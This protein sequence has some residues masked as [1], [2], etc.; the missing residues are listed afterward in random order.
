MPHL[1]KAI[2]HFPKWGLTVSDDLHAIVESELYSPDS[3]F[4]IPD[5]EHELCEISEQACFARFAE[6]ERDM[7]RHQIPY[8]IR[9]KLP[10]KGMPTQRSWRPG[11][12]GEVEFQVM[13]EPAVL[14]ETL[15][16][17][18]TQFPD[19]VPS[20]I[21]NTLCFEAENAIT[22][23]SDWHSADAKPVIEGFDNYIQDLAKSISEFDISHDLNAVVRNLKLSEANEI[24]KSGTKSQ[25][26]Y[27]VNLLGVNEAKLM[28]AD[29]IEPHNKR[30]ANPDTPP[31]LT[32]F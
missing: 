30:R 5:N 19:A 28:L 15:K 26:T 21:I 27:L 11:V 24:N 20:S 23:L 6:L 16:N 1:L 22:P 13:D 3:H 14:T 25:L 29:L 17:L 18:T 10:G 8:D 2:I 7:K 32:R 4:I 12:E 31:G 9:F